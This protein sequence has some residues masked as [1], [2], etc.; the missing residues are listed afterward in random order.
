MSDTDES[1]QDQQVDVVDKKRQARLN[2]LVKAREKAKQLKEASGLPTGKKIK[3]LK[4]ETREVTDLSATAKLEELK[5]KKEE[6]LKQM[7]QYS[8]KQPPEAEETIIQ[9]PKPKP[10]P[11]KDET[12][13]DEEYVKPKKRSC[14]APKRKKKIVYYDDSEDDEEEDNGVVYRRRKHEQSKDEMKEYY[15]QI[16]AS[17]RGEV[18]ATHKSKQDNEEDELRKRLIRSLNPDY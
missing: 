8:A 9:K 7:E 14:L 3:Q 4:K 15:D 17:V 18:E 1:I 2:N 11:K 6:L 13:D 16:L 5:K 10:K 12:S